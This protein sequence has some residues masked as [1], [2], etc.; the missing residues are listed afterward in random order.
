VECGKCLKCRFWEVVDTL[1]DNLAPGEPTLGKCTATPHLSSVLEHDDNDD[2]FRERLVGKGLT[3]LAFASDAE[4][5]AA[6]L[7]TKPDFGCV[8]FKPGKHTKKH[9]PS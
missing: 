5:F 1:M 3:S 6:S 9:I 4:C 7:I 8:I 2:E